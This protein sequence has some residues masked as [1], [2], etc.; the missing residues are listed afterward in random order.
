VKPLSQ[1]DR[2]LAALQDGREHEMRDIHVVAGFCR[3]NSRVSELRKR[4]YVITCRREGR[5]Y[6]YRL[7]KP[8]PVYVCAVDESAGVSEQLALPDSVA[9]HLYRDMARTPL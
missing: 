6:W 3:L 8:E 2:I 5:E 1:N 9:A 7:V 4:G